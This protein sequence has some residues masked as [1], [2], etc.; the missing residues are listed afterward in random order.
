MIIVSDTSP[1]NYLLILGE[2]DLLPRLFGSVVIPKAVAEELRHPKAPSEVKA[3]VESS[4]EWLEVREAP[5]G[6]PIDGIDS[7]ES[8]AICLAL[9][10]K[11]DLLII[12]DAAGRAAARARGLRVTGVLGIFERAADLGWIDLGHCLER[13]ASET[14]FHLSPKLLAERLEHWR[15]SK[16][17][18]RGA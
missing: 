9:Q 14:T 3:F 1:L 8:E 10:T 5:A 2:V 4:P 16:G 17:G 15:E 12:D 18:H 11:A 7:G 13:L 6:E